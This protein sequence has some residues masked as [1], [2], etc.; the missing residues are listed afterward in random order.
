M[1]WGGLE[2]E[3]IWT[4]RLNRYFDVALVRPDFAELRGALVGYLN[5][6]TLRGEDPE[7]LATS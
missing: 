7:A 2:G 6:A 5:G 3:S 4:R 1:A